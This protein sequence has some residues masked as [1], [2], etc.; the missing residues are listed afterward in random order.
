MLRWNFSA[1]EISSLWTDKL[2]MNPDSTG[3]R[4][5]MRRGLIGF[6]GREGFSL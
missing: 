6:W 5:K 4:Q 2:K 1:L 3:K